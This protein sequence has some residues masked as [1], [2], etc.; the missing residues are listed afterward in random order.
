MDIPE[1]QT[2]DLQN[3]ARAERKSL[4]D[5]IKEHENKDTQSKIRSS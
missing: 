5:V 2:I 4:E 1:R 3:I